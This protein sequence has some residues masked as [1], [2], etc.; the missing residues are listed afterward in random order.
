MKQFSIDDERFP[1]KQTQWF[2]AG[3]KEDGLRPNM[4]EVRDEDT[5]RKIEIYRSTRS[6]ASARGW[7]ISAS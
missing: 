3:C 4:V 1:P 7:S 6:S 5:R 2:I